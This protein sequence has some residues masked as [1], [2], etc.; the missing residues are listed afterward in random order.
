MKESRHQGM[1]T[2]KF[3][4]CEV[5]EQV[6]LIKSKIRTVLPLG[7]WDKEEPTGNFPGGDSDVVDKGLHYA[8]YISVETQLTPV[9]FAIWIV[10]LKGK[11]KPGL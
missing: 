10:C 8:D 7:S 3:H 9:H 5:Q 4:A 2:I 11:E 6:N 1:P